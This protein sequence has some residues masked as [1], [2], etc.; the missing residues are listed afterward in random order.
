M[1]VDPITEPFT[2]AAPEQMHVAVVHTAD[3][4]R[5]VAACLSRGGLTHRLAEYVRERAPHQLW[6]DDAGRLLG[7]LA[8]GDAGAA[9]ELYFA[10][11]GERWDPE[12]LVVD[13]VPVG[14]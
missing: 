12:W 2:P 8:G 11:V 1:T 10:S 13:T 5:L 6:P 9:V 14:A 3:A 7:L 4:V